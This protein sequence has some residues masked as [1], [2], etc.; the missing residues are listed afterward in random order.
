MNARFKPFRAPGTL[1]FVTLSVA[2]PSTAFLARGVRVLA[3]PGAAATCI[4]Q[5]TECSLAFAT[6]TLAA[7]TALAFIAAGVAAVY[8]GRLVRLEHERMVSIVP[9]HDA[10]HVSAPTVSS[11]TI[12][13]TG[14]LSA[15]TPGAKELRNYAPVLYEVVNLGRTP[16]LRLTAR[17]RF[18]RG[19][20]LGTMPCEVTFGNIVQHGVVHV[21][22]YL[23]TSHPARFV[24]EFTDLMSKRGPVEIHGTDKDRPG[25]VEGNVSI[26][27]PFGSGPARREPSEIGRELVNELRGIKHALTRVAGNHLGSDDTATKVQRSN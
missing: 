18:Q 22:V 1:A 8:T 5:G 17:C 4:F 7:V 11:I 3:L 20:L 2:L 25:K 10:G 12:T 15:N 26:A 16:L 21:G 23:H 13:D 9:C 24:L 19:A 27:L 14:D 6:W